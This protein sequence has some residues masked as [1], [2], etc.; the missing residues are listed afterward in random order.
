MNIIFEAIVSTGLLPI[1]ALIF[2][3]AWA[4]GNGWC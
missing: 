3:A 1:I 4:K 2:T